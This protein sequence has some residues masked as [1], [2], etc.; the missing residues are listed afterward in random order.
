MEVVDGI[1]EIIDVVNEKEIVGVDD[2]ES[3]T[4]KGGP[5]VGVLAYDLLATKDNDIHHT[6]GLYTELV[7]LVDSRNRIGPLLGANVENKSPDNSPDGEEDGDLVVPIHAGKNEEGGHLARV[8]DATHN[9][10]TG[11]HATHPRIILLHAKLNT[12]PV[13]VDD[14]EG[15]HYHEDIPSHL[16]HSHYDA[17]ESNTEEST[18]ID[19]RLHIVVL[20][21]N[22]NRLNRTDLDAPHDKDGCTRTAHGLRLGG[23]PST[24]T[25]EEIGHLTHLEVDE[26]NYADSHH[27]KKSSGGH[28][29]LTEGL[30]TTHDE[31]SGHHHSPPLHG[32]S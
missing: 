30:Y 18:G 32:N 21:D 4:K 5:I 26:E 28:Y 15:L 12:R 2:T 27:G 3:K 25:D 11:K 16:G 19:L 9:K 23:T 20:H 7:K 1:V 24:E 31:I 14:T 13:I 29:N 10:K 8:L 17:K 22:N 6:P